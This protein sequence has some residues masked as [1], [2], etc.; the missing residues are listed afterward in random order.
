MNVTD[1]NKVNVYLSKDLNEKSKKVAEQ[2]RMSRI[3]Y[4]SMILEQ[5]I[6]NDANEILQK[7]DNL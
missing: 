3:Q 6:T 1:K 2:K 5:Q 7:S 4:L